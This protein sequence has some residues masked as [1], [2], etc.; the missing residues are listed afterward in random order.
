MTILTIHKMGPSEK[1]DGLWGMKGVGEHHSCD[2]S[3]PF[4][5]HLADH[6]REVHACDLDER[7]QF[8]EAIQAAVAAD[9]GPD[10]RLPARYLQRIN[11]CRASPAHRAEPF[12][13]SRIG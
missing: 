3:H 1:S 7:I 5:F 10:R 11:Y 2:L 4:K 6:C 12:P 8:P 13:H 9:F